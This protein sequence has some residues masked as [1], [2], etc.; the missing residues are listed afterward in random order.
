MAYLFFLELYCFE[1]TSL[2]EWAGWMCLMGDCFQLT[3]PQSGLIGFRR[4]S[5]SR[6]SWPWTK[7]MH[8]TC[9]W[10]QGQNGQFFWRRLPPFPNYSGSTAIFA[11]DSFSSSAWCFLSS[12]E[13]QKSYQRRPFVQFETK[14][15]S[16]WRNKRSYKTFAASATVKRM[17]FIRRTHSETWT[18]ASLR[19]GVISNDD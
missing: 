15:I 6:C 8:K 19:P 7:N 10:Y 11:F 2:A 1:I 18:Q 4:T 17:D 16:F 12:R 3:A 13:S 5:F 9:V 14:E